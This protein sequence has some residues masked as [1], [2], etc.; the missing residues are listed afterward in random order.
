[1]NGTYCGGLCFHMVIE[2]SAVVPAGGGVGLEN[3]VRWCLGDTV[4]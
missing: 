4:L 1:M 2:L 3:S